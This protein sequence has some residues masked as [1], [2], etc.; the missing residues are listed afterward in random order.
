MRLEEPEQDD[1]EKC[2]ALSWHLQS[3]SDPSLIIPASKVW[4][5]EEAERKLVLQNRLK[6]QT[7]PA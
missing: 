3:V 7:V 1:G 4:M 2:W 5:P 6:S